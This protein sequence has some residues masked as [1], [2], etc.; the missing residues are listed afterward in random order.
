MDM[1]TPTA[2]ITRQPIPDLHP[3]KHYTANSEKGSCA[4]LGLQVQYLRQKF[5]RNDVSLLESAAHF[6]KNA[7]F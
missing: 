7:H 2:G 1:V 5:V 3:P 4:R 6:R